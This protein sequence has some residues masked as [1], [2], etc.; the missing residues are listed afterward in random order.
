MSYDREGEKQLL[1]DDLTKF[2]DL[3]HR[4]LV[5]LSV[6]WRKNQKTM[7]F[8]LDRSKIL[9]INVLIDVLACQRYVK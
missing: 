4:S 8:Y 7:V 9:F 3:N 2:V 5:L 6:E 1:T